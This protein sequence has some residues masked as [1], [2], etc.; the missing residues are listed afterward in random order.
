MIAIEEFVIDKMSSYVAG[1]MKPE[2]AARFTRGELLSIYRGDHYGRD[3][4]G[5][6]QKTPPPENL[7]LETAMRK[8]DTAIAEIISSTVP[9]EKPR[10]VYRSSEAI[11]RALA[12]GVGIKPFFAKSGDN[13]P[14]AY[15]TDRQ[16]IAAMWSEGQRRFKAFVR[17]RFLALDI[18]RK[19]G[20]PDGL[21]A[22]Y[23][24]FP[25]QTLPAELQELPRSF[26]CY[27]QTPSGGFHLYF[28][29]EGPEVNLRELATGIEIKEWQITCP[30][31]RKE[32]GE[33]ILHGELDKAPPLYGLIID[34]IEETK[35]RKEQ[36]KQEKAE[37]SKPRTKAAADRPAQFTQQPRI[38][39]DDLAREA[40]S[41]YS[42]HHDRQ[43]SFSGRAC[44]CKFSGAETL[45]YV[46]SRSDIFGND[47]DTENTV[48][49]VYRDY[50]AA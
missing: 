5:K 37:R 38:T 47:S 42:G 13:D 48:M 16:Q 7:D 32:C 14:D 41:A 33:Y 24:I 2:N 10:S 21:E 4:A 44:R 12:V 34:A 17:S 3:V 26:P 8:C 23:R 29:Y 31:S 18:D 27:V 46:K 36:E 50:G 28:K 40:A 15:T 35:R 49:S 45:L 9:V 30:G 39:L 43:V 22:F 6:P 25:K 20:K 19:P 11:K 1:G